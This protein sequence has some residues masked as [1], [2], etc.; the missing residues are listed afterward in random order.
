MAQVYA[1]ANAL[2][3]HLMKSFQKNFP[4]QRIIVFTNPRSEMHFWDRPVDY[5]Y[6]IRPPLL[7]DLI[8]ESKRDSDFTPD[9]CDRVSA[10][11]KQFTSIL[12]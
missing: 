4:I 12:G 7:L 9:F 5:V 2:Q 11:I 8:Q 3:A 1:E 6:I 10:E